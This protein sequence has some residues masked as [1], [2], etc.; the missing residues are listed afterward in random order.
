MCRGHKSAVGDV[1]LFFLYRDLTKISMSFYKVSFVLPTAH[2][3]YLLWRISGI[4]CICKGRVTPRAPIEL[5]KMSS[6][7]L[8]PLTCTI[9]CDNKAQTSMPTWIYYKAAQGGASQILLEFGMKLEG[10]KD[11]KTV[12]S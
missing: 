7:L 10:M 9:T 1:A 11:V 2:L 5:C 6:K 12:L 3:V 8:L 4:K